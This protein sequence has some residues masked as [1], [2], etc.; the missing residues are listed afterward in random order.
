MFMTLWLWR[1]WY[2]YYSTYFEPKLVQFAILCLL[3]L[4]KLASESNDGEVVTTV[5]NGLHSLL[6]EYKGL[7]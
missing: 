1:V 2:F 7:G 4:L 6:A 5:I 3:L